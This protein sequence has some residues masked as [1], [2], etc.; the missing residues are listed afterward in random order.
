MPPKKDKF[1]PQKGNIYQFFKPVP[2]KPQ[3]KD[4][5]TNISDKPSITITKKENEQ[6]TPQSEPADAQPLSSDPQM[7]SQLTIE[8][9]DEESGLSDTRSDI[10]E[11]SEPHAASHPP[12]TVADRE[13]G[14]SLPHPQPAE[15]NPSL[16]SDEDSDLSD[17]GSDPSEPSPPHIISY[18]P[19]STSTPAGELPAAARTAR[20]RT[21][22]APQ[23]NAQAKDKGL[24][25]QPL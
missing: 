6:P 10:L 5:T 24:Q 21:A 1:P 13:N 22:P 25:K 23:T 11:L 4:A 18:E 17:L 14:L 16:D 2:P 3:T 19:A 7:T 9:S 12:T 8:D 20:A 15:G